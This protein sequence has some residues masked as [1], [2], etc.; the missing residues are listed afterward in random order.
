MLT[1]NVLDVG[2]CDPD[3]AAIRGLLSAG[4][5]ATIDRVMFVPEALRA[6][7][8]KKYDLVLVNRLIFADRSD[9]LALVTAMKS[10]PQHA[11]IPV[12][13]ISNFPDAQQR[14]IA[15]GA[16]PG[17][18][19]AALWATETIGTLAK[20]LTLKTGPATQTSPTG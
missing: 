14:A 3:H 16:V 10:H 7:N 17:F 5:N 8:A 1:K 9:G 13:M 18:G 12:M 11:A 15:A 20:Y 6:L 4:F 19:K 2:N